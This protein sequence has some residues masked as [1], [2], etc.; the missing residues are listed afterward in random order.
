MT[1]LRWK[2]TTY[3]WS[4][5]STH[6]GPFVGLCVWAIMWHERSVRHVI[7]LP[8]GSV[9]AKNSLACNKEMQKVNKCKGETIYNE[10]SFAKK[11]CIVK[12]E[13]CKNYVHLKWK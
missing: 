12:G 10:G 9:G 5:N 1:L 2:N 4:R 8:P 11:K 6:H 13:E 3:K 7:S